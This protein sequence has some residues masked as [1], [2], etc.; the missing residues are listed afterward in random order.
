MSMTK[1]RF[2]GIVKNHQMKIDSD[3]SSHRHLVFKE[4][5]S[6]AYHFNITTWPGY[7]CV[8]GDMG[9]FVFKYP[10]P[11]MFSFFRDKKPDWGINPGYWEEKV[12]AQPMHGGGVK[13]YSRNKT[14]AQLRELLEDHK[15]YLAECN[16]PDQQENIAAAESYVSE[17]IATYLEDKYEAVSAL[18]NWDY[19]LAGGMSFDCVSD[20]LQEEFT[21]QYLFCCHAVV[22]AIK[23]YDN[24]Q[25]NV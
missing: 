7:L 22:W 18:R 25:E 5:S 6:S 12:C 8:S 1:D 21:A 20:A 24:H 13:I 2:L 23:Q 17:I 19:D 4:P 9:C 3:S 11:D 16:E 10:M 14:E 15:E